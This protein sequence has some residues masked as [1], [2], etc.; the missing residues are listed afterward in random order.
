LFII[1]TGT[2]TARTVIGASSL[3]FY[4]HQQVMTSL[5]TKVHSPVTIT[6]NMEKKNEGKIHGVNKEVHELMKVRVS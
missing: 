3:G 2:G 4:T 6:M 5:Q 1:P